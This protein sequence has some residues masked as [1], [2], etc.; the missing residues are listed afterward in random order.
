MN[1]VFE[2]AVQNI[3]CKSAPEESML[4]LIS[5]QLGGDAVAESMAREIL[6]EC[7]RD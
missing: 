6:S 5:R 4:S 7:S 2:T 3:L 1:P